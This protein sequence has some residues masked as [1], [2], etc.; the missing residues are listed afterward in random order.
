MQSVWAAPRCAAKRE[1]GKIQPKDRKG[2]ESKSSRGDQSTQHV[3]G[4]FIK[5]AKIIKS[6]PLLLT[7]RH[8]RKELIAHSEPNGVPL[9]D[10]LV[11]TVQE[12]AAGLHLLWSHLWA[13]G[14]RAV[15]KEVTN[16]SLKSMTNVELD[17]SLPCISG[18]ARLS[19]L[20]RLEEGKGQDFYFVLLFAGWSR[21]ASAGV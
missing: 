11:W 20:S 6:I 2:C 18:Q 16:F 19:H 3:L 17:V 21:V 14:P 13:L 10:T 12:D 4:Q 8:C 1:G 5:M 7:R 15:T 9:S